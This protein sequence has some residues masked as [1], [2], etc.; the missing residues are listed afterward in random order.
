LPE[1]AENEPSQQRRNAGG[2]SHVT[3][4]AHRVLERRRN[5]RRI[6][7]VAAHEIE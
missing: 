5:R 3:E 2:N 1:T 7:S 4:Q 6:G